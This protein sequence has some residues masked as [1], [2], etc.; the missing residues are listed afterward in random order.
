M[1][2]EKVS[3]AEALLSGL[4]GEKGKGMETYRS[5]VEEIK[6]QVELFKELAQSVKEDGV[7]SKNINKKKALLFGAYALMGII[8]SNLL[9]PDSAGAAESHQEGHGPVLGAPNIMVISQLIWL[10][11][12]QQS[13]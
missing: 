2:P 1:P 6:A 3:K 7:V 5:V 13:I 8:S 11:R 4:L 9:G 12:K 10:T